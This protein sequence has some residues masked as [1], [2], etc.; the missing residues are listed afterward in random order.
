MEDSR[1]IDVWQVY[2]GPVTVLISDPFPLRMQEMY[3]DGSCIVGRLQR[4]H[5]QPNTGDLQ[6]QVTTGALAFVASQGGAY[7]PSGIAAENTV[8]LQ[9]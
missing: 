6:G 2:R 3:G 5:Q 9:I 1:I 8:A 4:G 7:D